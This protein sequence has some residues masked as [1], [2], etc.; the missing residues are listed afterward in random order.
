MRSRPIPAGLATFAVLQIFCGLALATAGVLATIGVPVMVVFDSCCNNPGQSN[1]NTQQVMQAHTHY[2]AVMIVADFL[3]AVPPLLAGWFILKARRAGW[4]MSH[5][6][7]LS[8]MGNAVARI[9]AGNFL[10]PITI[11]GF[12]LAAVMIV[13][14]FTPAAR[15]YFVREAELDQITPPPLP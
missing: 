1:A 9:V 13:Y 15:N 2:L 10:L 6:A 14:L 12:I 8:L 3:A 7:A 11:I 5:I 4:V